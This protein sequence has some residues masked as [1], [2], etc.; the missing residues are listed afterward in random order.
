[1]TINEMQT[2][3]L[4]EYAGQPQIKQ[5][6][7][8]MALTRLKGIYKASPDP[9][10]LKRCKDELNA[11]FAKYPSIMKDDYHWIISL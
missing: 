7:M 3:K 10:T 2:K 4:L 9:A 11:I 8:N 1:M 5:L 6:G